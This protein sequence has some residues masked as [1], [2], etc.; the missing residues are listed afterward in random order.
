MR[1]VV[2]RS[3]SLVDLLLLV[4]VLWFGSYAYLYIFGLGGPKPL[5][6]YF[7]L[8]GFALLYV[9]TRIGMRRPW[10]I[11][12]DK[13]FRYFMAWLAGYAVYGAFEFLR[14][15]TDAVATQALITLS[16]SVLLAGAFALLMAAPRRLFA[17]AGAFAVLALVGTAMN[18]VDFVDP[19]FSNVPG[20]AAG[21]YV[22]PT[23]AGNFI[24]LAMV[25]G[26]TVVPRRLRLPFV[27]LCGVG[28]LPT[29]S[30]ESWLI[31]G[32][33]VV[34]LGWE[35]YFGNA[36]QRLLMVVLAAVIGGGFTAL[37]FGGRVGRLVA[38]SSLQAYLTPN[39][40][41]RL[42]IDAPVLSGES[43]EARQSLVFYSL[44]EAAKAPWLGNGLGYSSDWN[45]SAG[46]HDMYLLFL[47][48]GGIL[49]L[50]LYLGLL[51]LLWCAGVG[52]GQVIAL[53]IAISS[54]FSHNHL[55]Q[56]AILMVLAFVFAH[57]AVT[58]AEARQR[59]RTKAPA[60]A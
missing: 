55:D 43:A 41:A 15:P 44:D 38:N 42:G 36:R 53:Q 19:T 32:L 30:R 45:Y 11:K 27:L 54:F 17:V 10:L 34:W 8:L 37:L 21:L 7:L 12:Q 48:E 52:A 14:S 18:V 13:W 59:T 28:I 16:E 6:S 56:S 23:I 22:N 5:Y 60:L 2:A 4:F 20:R 9:L 47:V 25:A 3:I 31:W 51:V 24:A 50:A 49:G 26:V 58:R 33:A 1:L 39:T 35:G 29:F 46:T 40:A 57:G